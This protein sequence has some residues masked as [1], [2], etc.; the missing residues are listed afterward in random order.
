MVMRAVPD[1]SGACGK[2]RSGAA[3]TRPL[4][5]RTISPNSYF[6]I[7]PPEAAHLLTRDE[8]GGSAATLSGYYLYCTTDG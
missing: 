6:R 5:Y 2:W 8:L 1:K 4:R 7:C 3:I